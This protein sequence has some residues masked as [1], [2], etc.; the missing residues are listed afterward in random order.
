ME[1]FHGSSVLVFAFIS[2][3]VVSSLKFRAYD[4]AAAQTHNILPARAFT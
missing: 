1:Y 2:P 3:A 4:T